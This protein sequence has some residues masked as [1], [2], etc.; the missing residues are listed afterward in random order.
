MSRPAALRH[1]L[2]TEWVPIA[3]LVP[4]ER[5]PRINDAAAVR[6]ARTIEAHGWTTPLLVQAGT[7]RV[8][9]GHTRLKAAALL[10]LDEVPIVRLDVDDRRATEIALA[11]NRLGELAEWD[12][13][14][15]AALLAELAA[16][17][18]DR[19]RRT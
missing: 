18:P 10:G 15:L 12:D 6:L 13:D 14:G 19:S 3:G 7:G 9:A 8:I 11:D 16:E 2:A 1:D 4:W 17:R 5:N